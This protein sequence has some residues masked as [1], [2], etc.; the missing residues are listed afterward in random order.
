MK[1]NLLIIFVMISVLLMT[2]FM[3]FVGCS[4][5]QAAIE[6][7]APVAVDEYYE[8]TTMV[9][10]AAAAE[11]AT[12][13]GE[14]MA[15]SDST[16]VAGSGLPNVVQKII[17]SAYISIEVEKGTFQDKIIVV[18]NIAESNGGFVS[19][20]ESY[21]NPEG[22]IAS[23]KIVIRIP[24]EK[25]NSVV[26]EIKKVGKIESISISGQDVTQEYVDL[27]SRLRNY[28]VQEK[29]LL[30]LMEKST[31]VSD[32]IE[33][34]RELSNVQGEIEVIKGRMNYLD[35]L[36]SMSSIDIDLHEPEVAAPIE[37][38]G[39]VNA[40]KRGAEGALKVLNGIAF[41]F[42]MISPLLVL[43]AIIVLIVWGSKRSRNK[44]RAR[45]AAEEASKQLEQK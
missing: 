42:I 37:G 7:P 24:G 23:G 29:V 32:S 41:F 44:R 43:A 3:F 38:G 40:V 28:Q 35:N 14:E 2:C 31:K 10:E 30:E 8:E 19:N 34:Q 27:E 33:V 9:S 18:T 39:F 13:K 11:F 15:T 25:F 45:R 17:K 4:R 36:V 6:E 1:K 5:S 22:N 12:E 26:E 20:T 21:S 16:N